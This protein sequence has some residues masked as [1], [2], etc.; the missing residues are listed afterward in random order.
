MHAVPG[1][2]LLPSN[3]SWLALLQFSMRGGL[4]FDH[5]SCTARLLMWHRRSVAMGLFSLSHYLL[6]P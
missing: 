1:W 5:Y 4:T 6:S 3:L 2:L